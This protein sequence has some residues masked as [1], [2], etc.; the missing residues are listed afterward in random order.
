VALGG[1]CNGKYCVRGLTC[2]GGTCERATIGK[3]GDDC[4]YVS[5]R[6]VQCDEDLTC[7][8]V[9]SSGSRA[10]V[11]VQSQFA[12]IGQ[13]CNTPGT[14]GCA[15]TLW[16]DGGTCRLREAS[17]CSLAPADAGPDAATDAATPPKDAN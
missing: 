4:S 9:G 1:D 16:C 8:E 17:R 5:G 12:Q 3:L 14:M 15:R 13:A 10:C 6:E 2:T 7:Q 11:S